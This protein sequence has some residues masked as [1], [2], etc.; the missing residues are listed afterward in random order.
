M[1]MNTDIGLFPKSSHLGR[2]NTMTDSGYKNDM[3]INE[4]V[5]MATVRVAELFKKEESSYLRKYDITFSQ[6]NIL[7]VL[8]ASENGQ[9][10]MK[11]VQKIMLVSRA[12]MTG[13]T[14]RLEKLGYIIRK[15]APEDERLKYLE[16]TPKGKDVVRRIALNKEEVLDKYLTNYPEEKKIELLNVFRQILR[17]KPA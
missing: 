5:M 13:I 9:N 8:D 1:K 7:R 3:N 15:N 16:L 11:N 12:N 10:T 14:K 4:K 2:E 17:K 6:Y